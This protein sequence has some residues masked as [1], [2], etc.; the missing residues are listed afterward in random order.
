M[1][2]KRVEKERERGKRRRNVL[3]TLKEA[4]YL[5]THIAE[6][7]S[8]ADTQHMHTLSYTHTHKNTH[9]EMSPKVKMNQEEE[10]KGVGQR[11]KG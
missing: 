7:P 2:T 4:S 11:Q 5:P 3:I 10:R 9:S 6:Y 1:R 8:Q